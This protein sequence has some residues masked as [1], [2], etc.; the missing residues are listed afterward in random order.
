MLAP[1]CAKLLTTP[2][3][4]GSPIIQTIGIVLVARRAAAVAVTPVTKR[5][6][7]GMR[8]SS[9]ASLGRRSAIPLASRLSRRKSRPST[10]PSSRSPSMIASLVSWP[11]RASATARERRP[12]RYTL[13]TCC[14]PAPSGAEMRLGLGV[15]AIVQLASPGTGTNSGRHIGRLAGLATLRPSGDARSPRCPIACL[16]RAVLLQMF[17]TESRGPVSRAPG[18]PRT[19]LAAGHASSRTQPALLILRSVPGHGHGA[20]PLG[21]DRCQPRLN[22]RQTLLP[23]PN[24]PREAL[25]LWLVRGCSGVQFSLVGSKILRQLGPLTFKGLSLVRRRW[26]LGE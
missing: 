3:P 19:R 9:S 5:T 24:L 7:T 22:L 23:P 11:G 16:I 14:A 1:G 13:P 2:W 6:S 26:H 15:H 12:I 20:L 4:T 25:P 21:A 18:L 10:Y 8:T 17:A